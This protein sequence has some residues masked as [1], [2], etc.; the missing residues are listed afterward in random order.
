MSSVTLASVVSETA[1]AS[2]RFVT[3]C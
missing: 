3:S 2:N 1:I